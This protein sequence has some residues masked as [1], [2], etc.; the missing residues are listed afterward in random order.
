MLE[1]FLVIQKFTF[2]II[3]MS[4]CHVN[5]NVNDN[6]LSIVLVFVRSSHVAVSQSVKFTMIL[7]MVSLG[8]DLDTDTG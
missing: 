4:M 2:L 7:P 6:A 1:I 5:V 3:I 8:T